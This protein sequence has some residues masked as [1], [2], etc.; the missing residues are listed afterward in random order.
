M[1][2]VQD[3]GQK[4]TRIKGSNGCFM[5]TVWALCFLVSVAGFVAGGIFNE[6]IIAVGVIFF[7]IPFFFMGGFVVIAPNYAVV[8]QFCGKYVG[9]IR[10]NGFWFINPYY[11]KQLVSLKINNFETSRIKVNDANGSPIEIA[12]V[13]VWRILDTYEALYEIENYKD[14]LHIQAEAAL[15]QS[16]SLF[17]YEASQEGEVALRSSPVEVGESL[18]TEIQ[19]RL[20]K[21]GIE[22]VEAKITHLAYSAEIASAMLRK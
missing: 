9:T 19:A 10:E 1:D 7:V 3:P 5:L 4:E 13:V 21:A 16:T 11:T 18:R 17:P 8:C 20:D 2:N 12:A 15:R 22:I 14:Y 6:A